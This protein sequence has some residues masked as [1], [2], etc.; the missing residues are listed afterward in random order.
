MGGNNVI[1]AGENT[2][3]RKENQ[4]LGNDNGRMKRIRNNDS[5]NSSE[6]PSKDRAR[7]PDTYNSRKPTKK[8]AGAQTGHR[9]VAP[10]RL[11]WKRRYGTA[12]WGHQAYVFLRHLSLRCY[13]VNY[14]RC[15]TSISGCILKISRITTTV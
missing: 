14:A 15:I 13:F 12:L 6:P 9:A 7:P 3:L 4:L 1:L 10:Q 8:K 2:A 11:T 5:P